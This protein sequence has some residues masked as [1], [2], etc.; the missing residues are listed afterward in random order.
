MTDFMLLEIGKNNVTVAPLC[1]SLPLW[2][3]WKLSPRVASLSGLCCLRLTANH[4]DRDPIIDHRIR[5][6]INTA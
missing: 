5:I 2:Q 3:D 1:I 6:A 4:R